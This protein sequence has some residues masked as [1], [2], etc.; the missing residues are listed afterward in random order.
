MKTA[1]G[2]AQ[3]YYVNDANG[4][5]YY[6]KTA[7]GDMAGSDT[8]ITN[9]TD[10]LTVSEVM[11][12]SSITNNKFLKH[13]KDTVISDLPNAIEKLTIQQVFEEEIFENGTVKGEWW[14]ML[15]NEADCVA[16]GH[17]DPHTC[18]C[19]SDYGLKEMNTLIDNMKNN[20]H[21]STLDKL[22]ADGML[23]FGDGM[24]NSEVFTEIKVSDTT[25]LDVIVRVPQNGIWVE[26]K[27]S[28]VFVDEN[29][30]KKA[31]IGLLTVEETIEYAEG[32]IKIIDHINDLNS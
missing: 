9:L 32:L 15:H 10:R 23:S 13:V 5:V 27:A 26:K 24:L 21:L 7:L 6:K 22:A 8:L 29:G 31:R 1:A 18:T 3:L 4:A 20:I 11:D 30:V 19:V 16:A 25:T 12:E 28:E 2:D 17:T 14:Y